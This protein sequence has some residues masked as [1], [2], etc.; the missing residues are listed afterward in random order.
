MLAYIGLGSNLED[1]RR[2]IERALD[3]IREAD[4]TKLTS[5][6]SF[7]ESKPLL[8]MLGPKYLNAVCKIKTDL[9]QIIN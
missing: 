2:Q 6:S 8:D 4:K 1:P 5:V 7:Y 9:R 3:A